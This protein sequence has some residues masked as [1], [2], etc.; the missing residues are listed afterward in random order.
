ME[1]N[2][3]TTNEVNTKFYCEKCNYKCDYKAHYEQH[4]KSGKH[5][6][7]KITKVH[8]KERKERVKKT[9]NP[10]IHKCEKCEFTSNHI[11]N[12]KT[13]ILNNHST[14]EERKKEFLYYCEC[15]DYGIYSKDL[16]DNHLLKKRHLMK[17]K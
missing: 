7:G 10:T 17:S 2:T 5:L 3:D 15:C 11:Y 4:L 13:H 14:I 1:E 8:T 12:F 6:T 16:F 9:P